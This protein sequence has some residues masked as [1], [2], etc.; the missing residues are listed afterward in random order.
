MKQWQKAHTDIEKER[1]SQVEKD[2]ER[3]KRFKIGEKYN[4]SHDKKVQ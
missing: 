1:L 2:N 3:G 4:I